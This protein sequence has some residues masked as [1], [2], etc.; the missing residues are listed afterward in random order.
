LLLACLLSL[1]LLSSCATHPEP[2][3]SSKPQP[4]PFQFLGA[5]QKR[6]DGPGK[7]DDPVSF[8][9][10]DPG[11][12]YFEDAGEGFVDKFTPGGTPLLSF[13]EPRLRHGSGI[14][15]DR[16]GAIYVGDAAGRRVLIFF[17]N[18][19]FLRGMRVPARSQF[20]GT[21]AVSVDYDGNLYVPDP[22][23]TR[24]L[25]FNNRGV[26]LKFLNAPPDAVSARQRPSA[27]AP[28]PDGSVFV[29]YGQAGVV[30][31]YSSDGSL[32][33]VW[34]A[35]QPVAGFDAL[36][37]IT[38]TDRYVITAGPASPR[39]RVWTLDGALKLDSDLGGRIDGVRAPQIAVSSNEML[40]VFDPVAP[41]VYRFR[42]HF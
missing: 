17:P 19:T 18:G 11:N 3:P 37:G 10:D 38:V 27:V 16:G 2:N 1:P 31:K 40:L 22:A 28:A 29:A 12:V 36:T 39:I 7:L 23:E 41:R 24:V 32:I 13:G 34:S 21:M 14:A 33:K 8:A 26:R 20:S 9:V 25:K 4:A 5:W 30:R 15:V 6:G 35:A 42:M